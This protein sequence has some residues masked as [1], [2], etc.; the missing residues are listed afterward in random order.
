MATYGEWQYIRLTGNKG[1]QGETGETG[2]T[3][4]G[5]VSI[6]YKYAT[7]ETQTGAKTPYQD[8][9]PPLS[10]TAKFLW[11]QETITFTSES[12]KI[13][14]SILAVYGDKG[15]DGQDGED[16]DDGNGIA[17]T[18]YTYAT[19]QTQTGT[20]TSFNP[21]IPPL[22]ETNKYLW[23]R[24]VI[25]YT[26]GT[27]KQTDALIGVYGDRG[28]TG[29]QG[30]SNITINTTYTGT[31]ATL[32]GWASRSADTYSFSTFTSDY[33]KVKVGDLVWFVCTCNDNSSAYYNKKA[34][35]PRTIST[36]NSTSFITSSAGLSTQWEA[37]DGANGTIFTPS[38]DANGNISWTNDGGKTN[39]TTRNIKGDKGDTGNS[40]GTF[41]GALS[42][43][44][45]SKVLNDYFVNTS[46][47]ITYEWNGSSWVASTSAKK[48]MDGLN[49][50]INGGYNLSNFGTANTVVMY[51]NI[52]AQEIYADVIKGING[53]FENINVTG[54]S[55]F[56]GSIVSQAFTS[57]EPRSTQTNLSFLSSQQVIDGT[58]GHKAPCLLKST[59]MSQLGGYGTYYIEEG[60]ISYKELVNGSSIVTK[61]LIGLE[62]API[63]ISFTASDLFIYEK[64]STTNQLHYSIANFYNSP[65]V[66]PQPAGYYI[67][68]IAPCPTNADTTI[69]QITENSMVLGSQRG[70]ALTMNLFPKTSNSYDLGD[71][72][73]K[74]KNGY[75]NNLYGNLNGNVTGDVTGDVTG[76]AS[77]ATD[78]TYTRNIKNSNGSTTDC[79]NVVYSG[80]GVDC[81]SK[82]GE[83]AYVKLK[84]FGGS[85][86]KAYIG[87]VN[88]A[89]KA[90]EATTATTATNADKLYIVGKGNVKCSE[91]VNGQYAKLIGTD[92]NGT[93]VPV[94]VGSADTA[95]EATKA[96]QIKINDTSSFSGLMAVTQITIG[97]DGILHYKGYD[98]SGNVVDKGTATVYAC[99]A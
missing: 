92:A 69:G 30:V 55:T 34:S 10:E 78:A 99:F 26:D 7:S 12:P 31:K 91:I 22:S 19:S 77:T 3:G 65:I 28:D 39:P 62:S 2:A 17:D 37:L 73:H 38:V 49:A 18:D 94:K 21:D 71:A 97:T 70:G 75:I 6:T 24:E 64:G 48:C 8:E 57:Y 83:N 5:V 27:T 25:T 96:S 68:D 95:T 81:A 85:T 98:A 4:N 9:I 36:I 52:L 50:L 80:E 90:N 74:W 20:K 67:Q 63:I 59:I 40:E 33:S 87:K 41:K 53:L 43:S 88:A 29:A 1:E 51:K 61:T 32:D 79:N 46:N 14:E 44:P 58:N 93:S 72:Y 82:D 42:S 54:K 45:S 86:V 66:T 16:G 84:K 89:F 23:Q 13:T 60:R 11:E 56:N 35:V 15:K 47:G 76:N